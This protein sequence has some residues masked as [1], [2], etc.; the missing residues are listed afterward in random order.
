MKKLLLIPIMFFVLTVECSQ[1][2]AQGT[3]SQKANFPGEA[4]NEAAGF[5]I[6][7]KG[8]IVA[9]NYA[10]SC[11]Y[12]KEVWEYAPSSDSWTQKANFPGEGRNGAAGFGINN[13]GYIVA[14]NYAGSC[15]FCNEVWEY[16]S[17]VSNI[18]EF[19]IMVLFSIFPNPF[20][21]QTTLQTDNFLHSATLTVDNVFGQTV[22]EIKNISGQTITLHRD[23]L[24]SGVYFVRL[25]QDN[26]IITTNKLV[27][28]D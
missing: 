10:S 1:T 14:G 2:L 21:D 28:T 13:K 17:S 12:C 19:Q 22:K 24:P 20:S 11:T 8:Y 26:K 18:N 4:R 15:T 25:T 9:G 5:G 16:N 27:I 6:N 7:N 3:W 23:N